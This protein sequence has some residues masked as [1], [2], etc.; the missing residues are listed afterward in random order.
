MIVRRSAMPSPGSTDRPSRASRGACRR[1]ARRRCGRSRGRCL[2]GAS[3]CSRDAR[4]RTGGRASVASGVLDQRD[5]LGDRGCDRPLGAALCLVGLD[6]DPHAG[7]LGLGGER[8]EPVDD[9]LARSSGSRPSPVPVRQTMPP[10]PKRGEPVDR[11]AERV[12]PLGRVGRA[13]EKRERQDRRDRRNRRCGPETALLE[14]L[15]RAAHRRLPGAST[16]RC[17]SRRGRRRSTPRGRPRSSPAP[18]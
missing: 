1:R 14:G 4:C 12:D 9:D 10:G 13:A 18:W 8:S 2:R 11:R 6:R 15:E 16:P 17:R 5:R 3:A 7:E